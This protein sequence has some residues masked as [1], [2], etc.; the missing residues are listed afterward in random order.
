MKIKELFTLVFLLSL[1]PE[2][3][4]HQPDIRNFASSHY[5]G[6]TQNWCISQSD[7][8]LMLF[9]NN[10]G[11][12]AFDSENWFL[13]PMANHTIVRSI[14]YNKANNIIYAG[15]SNEF[16][17]FQID[18]VTYLTVYKSLS[19]RLPATDKYFEEIAN[20]VEYNGC[21]SFQAKT[22]VFVLR[23]DGKFRIFRIGYRIECSAVVQGKYIV[24]C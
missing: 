19:S 24:A 15:A 16:G 21:I 13:F 22:R 5:G 17:Y 9:A 4:A 6:G 7:D 23:P 20:I 1:V 12:L 8:K 14:L 2:I 3:H 10:N 18:P 11:L